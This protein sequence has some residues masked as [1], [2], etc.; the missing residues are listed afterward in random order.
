ME[1]K[2]TLLVSVV[3]DIIG[4]FIDR[5]TNAM[6]NKSAFSGKQNDHFG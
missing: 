1:A 5:Y 2:F 3:E 6:M 4:C